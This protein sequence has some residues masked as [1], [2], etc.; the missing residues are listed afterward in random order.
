MGLRK[1]C[2]EQEIRRGMIS[3]F[4]ICKNGMPFIRHHIEEFKKLDEPWEWFIAEGSCNN[5][6]DTSWCAPQ[7]PGLSGDGT[8]EYLQRLSVKYDNVHVYRNRLWPCKTSMVNTL[9]SAMHHDGVLIQIDVD[10]FWTAEQL[11]KIS[12]L[13]RANPKHG[14]ARFDCR[15]YVGP[16][17]VSTKPG[18][19]GNR[20]GEWL[21]AWRFRVGDTFKSH[22]PPILNGPEPRVMENAQTRACGLVFDHLSWVSRNQVAFKEKFYKYDGAVAGW[23]RLQAQTALPCK[24][25]PFFHWADRDAVV[26][27]IEPSNR[28]KAI[29]SN[30][31]DA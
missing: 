6:R 7:E 29:L 18:T 10:E 22:E 28:I 23:D 14:A 11:A 3:I 16:D 21:R 25:K 5:K 17:L 12:F 4:T 13:F 24:L 1:L 19:Y 9:T 27:K 2:K 15:Y 30:R 31:S 26:E 8:T 20:K